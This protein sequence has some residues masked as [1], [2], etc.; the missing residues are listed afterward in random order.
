MNCVADRRLQGLAAVDRARH[1][2][3]EVRQRGDD[4]VL[5]RVLRELERPARGSITVVQ[6][7]SR[8]LR[9][10]RREQLADLVSDG[11]AQY[12]SDWFIAVRNFAARSGFLATQSVRTK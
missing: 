5:L 9:A 11:S 1:E 7:G 2:L 6:I 12:S 8:M 10:R 3:R 4:A